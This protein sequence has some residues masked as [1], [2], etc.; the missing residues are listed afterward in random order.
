VKGHGGHPLHIGIKPGAQSISMS[1]LRAVWRTADEA[2]FDHCWDYDHFQS[3][4][5][6]GLEQ[7]IWEGWSL[8]AAMAEATSRVR[9]GCLVTGNTYRHPS[10]LAKMAVTVDHL[11]GGRLEF[12]LGAAWAEHEHVGLGIDGLDHRVGRLSESLQVVSAL[13]GSDGRPSF[14]GRYYRL[15]EA[16]A[17]PKPL[18]QPHPPIWIGGGGPQVMRLVARH[19]DVWVAGYGVSAETVERLAEACGAIDRDPAELRHATECDW[20]GVSRDELVDRFGR[21]LEM[22][23]TEVVITLYRPRADEAAVRVAEAVPELRALGR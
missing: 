16:I 4:G 18:Q 23:F 12:G 22:G 17:E 8:L 3:Y 9:I 5:P 19:A 6:R 21:C 10:V 11:S 14:E 15:R 20:D 7:P 1:E 2:G 13:W